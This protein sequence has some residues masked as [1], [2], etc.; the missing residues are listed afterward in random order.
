MAAPPTRQIERC[1][2]RLR[3]GGGRVMAA[4][5]A[6]EDLPPGWEAGVSAV[7][8]SLSPQRPN[9]EEAPP[10][11]RPR[12]HELGAGSAR[13]LALAG[14]VHPGRCRLPPVEIPLT[15]A[16]FSA[17]RDFSR[18]APDDAYGADERRRL[19]D[20]LPFGSSFLRRGPGRVQRP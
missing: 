20:F 11:S 15:S 19:V 5:V 7:R 1:G 13:G 17:A 2:R 6:A 12:A 9:C 10:R 16:T 4:E 3:G 18:L 14:D 8:C